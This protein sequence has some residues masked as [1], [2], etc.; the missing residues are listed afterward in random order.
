MIPPLLI[1]QQKHREQL[2][3][4][5]KMNIPELFR[6]RKNAVR[7]AKTLKKPKTENWMNFT[8]EKLQLTAQA[9][10][11]TSLPDAVVQNQAI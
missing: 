1:K 4:H 5:L 6:K 11:F 8:P 9:M 7:E 3:L 2:I 10:F